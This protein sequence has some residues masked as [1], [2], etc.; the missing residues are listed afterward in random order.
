MVTNVL[1]NLPLCTA[2]QRK[3][4]INLRVCYDRISLGQL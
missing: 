1:Q 3:V 2:E 4:W